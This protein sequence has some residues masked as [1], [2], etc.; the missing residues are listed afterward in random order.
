[1]REALECKSLVPPKFRYSQLVKAGPNLYCSG[2]IALDNETGELVGE[3]PGEQS[4]IIL[5]NVQLLMDEFKLD[6]EDLA[7][8]R[9]FSSR[10]DR[11]AEINAAWEEIFAERTPP[12]R[13]SVGVSALPLGAAV[14][15]EFTF[16][17]E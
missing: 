12:G 5:R 7:F 6:W 14:E 8:V 11:F 17:K 4:R 16:Y 3:G 2:M 15:M 13:S 1:M 10:F 9:I